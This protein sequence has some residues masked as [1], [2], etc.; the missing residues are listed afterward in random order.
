[1][2]ILQTSFKP[3]VVTSHWLEEFT[4]C[5]PTAVK[6]INMTPYNRSEA[7]AASQ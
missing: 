2:F 3:H 7:V 6:F 5:A 4:N 1:M